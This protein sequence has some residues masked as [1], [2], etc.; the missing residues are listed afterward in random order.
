MLT[1]QVTLTRLTDEHFEMMLL[2]RAN[3]HFC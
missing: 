3:K 1:F 2:L